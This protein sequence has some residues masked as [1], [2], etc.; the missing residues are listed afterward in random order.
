LEVRGEQRIDRVVGDKGGCHEPASARRVPQH[1]PLEQSE[2]QGAHLS[3]LGALAASALDLNR[4]FFDV[5]AS[6][7]LHLIQQKGMSAEAL[8]DLLYRRSGMLGLSGVSSDFRELLAS[9][10]PRA[11]F[12]L[13]VFY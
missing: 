5:D 8:V 2:K 4:G 7:V 11:R 3:L 6:V 9:E 10:D 12:A 13:E 1:A